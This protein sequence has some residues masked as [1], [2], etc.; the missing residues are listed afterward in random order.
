MWTAD[1]IKEKSFASHLEKQKKHLLT[2]YKIEII[3]VV[4]ASGVL[5]IHLLN[6]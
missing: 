3:F 4:S 2:M 1:L 6:C 5:K